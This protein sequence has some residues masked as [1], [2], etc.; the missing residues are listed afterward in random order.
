MSENTDKRRP[1]DRRREELREKLESAHLQW[2]SNNR[3]SGNPPPLDLSFMEQNPER[4]GVKNTRF[5]R[6]VQQG[7]PAA[8]I[9]AVLARRR[10]G[11][12][13]RDGP[14]DRHDRLNQ[15]QR[16]PRPEVS[17]RKDLPRNL[18]SSLFHQRE[19]LDGHNAGIRA[20][21]L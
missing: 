6:T 20:N 7:C 1:E 21:K 3:E 9:K 15:Q 16:G 19:L 2:I 18:G 5:R 17:H 14:F 11:H 8:P 4:G 12:S 13:D 10:S